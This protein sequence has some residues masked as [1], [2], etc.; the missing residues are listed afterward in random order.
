MKVVRA[1]AC[2]VLP[3][4][5]LPRSTSRPMCMLVASKSG[6]QVQVHGLVFR[7]RSVDV[8]SSG[9]TMSGLQ[10]FSKTSSFYLICNASDFATNTFARNAN[11]FHRDESARRHLSKTHIT[12][13]EY[14]VRK[15]W[16]HKDMH[17]LTIPALVGVHLIQNP[18][19]LF[20]L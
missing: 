19:P 14:L 20:Q 2:Q 12:I 4:S 15:L 1:K 18:L 10:F 17:F 5:L 11:R 16:A 6:M 7:Y 8:V 9:Y 3:G 13:I